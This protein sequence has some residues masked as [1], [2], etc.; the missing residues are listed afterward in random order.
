MNLHLGSYCFYDETARDFYSPNDFI[1]AVGKE[2]RDFFT[3]DSDLTQYLEVSLLQVGL[4]CSYRSYPLNTR[5]NCTI[6]QVNQII[7]NGYYGSLNEGANNIAILKL[8]KAIDFSYGVNPVCL[9][10]MDADH[11]LKSNTSLAVS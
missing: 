3:T 2:I 1:V 8:E 4:T 10:F 6:V 11:V 5:F 9:G 7:S